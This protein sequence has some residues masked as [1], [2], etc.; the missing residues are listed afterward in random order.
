MPSIAPVPLH[1]GDAPQPPRSVRQLAM[2]MTPEPGEW[3]QTAISRWAFN[4]Y[5]CSRRDL[6]EAM[7]LGTLHPVEIRGLGVALR[8]ETADTISAAT[9]IS[10]VAV[11][12]MTQSMR[13]RCT[14]STFAEE[15]SRG[16]WFPYRERDLDSD[17]LYREITHKWC[18]DCL[19]D[20]PGVH[21]M[22]WR[23]PWMHLCFTHARVLATICAKCGKPPRIPVGSTAQMWDPNTCPNVDGASANDPCSE[24][25]H[26]TPSPRVDE[27]GPLYAAQARIMAMARSEDPLQRRQLY[28][29]ARVMEEVQDFDDDA[30]AA[31]ASV[32]IATVRNLQPR[33]L[34]RGHFVQY[35][36]TFTVLAAAAYSQTRNAE[37]SSHPQISSD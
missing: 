9:G 12:A 31:L 30:L 11:Y 34:E 37:L 27:R 7:G 21:E 8:P 17:P 16:V 4:T 28:E 32:D 36:K 33:R 13:D 20:R 1:I 26:Q 22:L 25:F 29:L 23:H 24:P 14:W 18:P 10:F 5:K 35:P 19:A 15:M 6:L 3:L 2:Q